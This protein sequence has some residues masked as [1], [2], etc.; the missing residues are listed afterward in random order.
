M[1]ANTNACIKMEVSED[2]PTEMH[3]E[4]STQED[5]EDVFTQTETYTVHKP[6]QQEMS[7]EISEMILENSAAEAMT[8]FESQLLSSPS[9]KKKTNY[10]HKDKTP[11]TVKMLKEKHRENERLR[12]HSL[13][14]HL[15]LICKGVPGSAE[16]GKET[17][18][19][20]MQR[21]ISYVAYLENTIKYMSSQLNVCPDPSWLKLTS[22]I[23]DI[24]KSG[25][26]RREFYA[27]S[28]DDSEDSEIFASNISCRL[29]L[30]SPTVD[31]TTD[32]MPSNKPSHKSPTLKIENFLQESQDSTCPSSSLYQDTDEDQSNNA[33]GCPGWVVPAEEVIIEESDNFDQLLGNNDYDHTIFELPSSTFESK[34]METPDEVEWLG[35]PDN[36]VF[37]EGKPENQF[38]IRCDPNFQDEQLSDM[39]HTIIVS[40][41]QVL[42]QTTI[43]FESDIDAMS[44]I[45]FDK[46]VGSYHRMENTHNQLDVQLVP[47]CN[48]RKQS[49]PRRVPLFNITNWTDID[50]KMDVEEYNHAEEKTD[51]ESKRV[52][53]GVLSELQSDIKKE[54]TETDQVPEIELARECEKVVKEASIEVTSK[55]DLRKSSWM[56]GFMMYSRIHRKRFIK[57]NPGLQASSISKMMGHT[58]RHMTPG[59]QQPYR[60]QA[61]ICSQELQK[62]L[63]ESYHP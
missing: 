9:S 13:N 60:D 43:K 57:E 46:C 62:M 12:H 20:M 44:R 37:Y 29:K 2:Q 50:L 1:A 53:I 30:S 28:S 38:G 33:S 58:W 47:R 14:Q 5:R 56:N 8:Y 23:K 17:K 7:S 16:D 31:S 39:S 6:I 10:Y 45:S 41:N 15:R 19:V 35:S 51:T 55:L 21:I 42:P 40:P 26:W 27:I 61:K 32:S 4:H 49:S 52:S 18:V 34:Y 22:S 25:T 11:N 54:C 24:E 63:D 36:C 48:K 59:Q 3:N